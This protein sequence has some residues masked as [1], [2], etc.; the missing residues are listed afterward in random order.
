M[1]PACCLFYCVN[2]HEHHHQTLFGSLSRCV[3]L[4]CNKK[5]SGLWWYKITSVHKSRPGPC[6]LS[7]VR[8]INVPGLCCLAPDV[9]KL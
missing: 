9:V 7:I 4:C 3:T 2:K 5:H 6:Y 8:E 1:I